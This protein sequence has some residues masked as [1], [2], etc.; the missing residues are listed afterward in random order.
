MKFSM[1]VLHILVDCRTPFYFLQYWSRGVIL[2]FDDSS[3][4]PLGTVHL[5]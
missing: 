2:I 1:D 4:L 3:N 5:V